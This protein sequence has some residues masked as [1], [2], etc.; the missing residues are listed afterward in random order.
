MEQQ[1]YEREIDLVRLFKAVVKKWKKMLIAGVIGGCLL[2]AFTVL[3]MTMKY[4]DP[5]EMEFQRAE[6][7][8]ALHEYNVTI[9]SYNRNIKNINTSIERQQDYN[10]KSVLM[11]INPYD[12][13]KGVLQYYIDTGYEINT[14]K[15]YQNPD[16]TNSV[17]NAYATNVNNGGLWKYIQEHIREEME[18]RYIQELVGVSVD[19][20][21]AMINVSVTGTT[22]TQCQELL[23]VIK[24]C[25][26]EYYK[27]I[28]KNIG[29]HDMSLITESVYATVDLG[30]QDT[31]LNNTQRIEDLNN[32]L[33]DQTFELMVYEREEEPEDTVITPTR[34][35]ISAIKF[36]IIGGVVGVFVAAAVFCVMYLL[37][38]TIRDEKDVEFYLDLPVLAVVPAMEG[39]EANVAAVKKNKKARLS[40]YGGK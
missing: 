11:D 9:E 1:T 28:V 18:F 35:V 19:Y 25:L 17:L 2:A 16:H 21:N 23:A 33:E 14:D 5:E 22:A 38:T 8:D 30:L 29:E 3:T 26:N 39:E 37:D 31:Q 7:Q 13:Q 24:A 36:A 10:D 12:V 34:I 40:Q 15:I 32:A 4:L 6:Y 27:E 20:G